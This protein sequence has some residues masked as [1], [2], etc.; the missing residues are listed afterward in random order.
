MPNHLYNL[1]AN[2]TLLRAVQKPLMAAELDAAAI[3]LESVYAAAFE[4]VQASAAYKE[5][6]DEMHEATK[7]LNNHALPR[8]LPHGS[9]LVLAYQQGQARLAG[10]TAR[11]RG[12]CVDAGL[13]CYPDA[14]P[15][16]PDLPAPAPMKY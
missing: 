6:R 14:V 1:K 15:K 5:A 11:L 7:P 4:M 12:F 3:E 8:R 13:P 16:P 10:A 2:A 9:P